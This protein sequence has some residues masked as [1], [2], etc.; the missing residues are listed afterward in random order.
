[1]ERSEAIDQIIQ[2]DVNAF[3]KQSLKG[4]G[5]CMC[6]CR[7]SNCLKKYCECFKNGV[8]CGG[9]CSCFECSNVGSHQS[10]KKG[11]KERERE[12]SMEE[13]SSVKKRAKLS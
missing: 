11:S 12:E 13:Y 6:N 2:R 9:E 5:K 10:K 7:K 8:E 1:M 3:S 4:K